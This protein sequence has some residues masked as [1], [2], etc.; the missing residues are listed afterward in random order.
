MTLRSIP[1]FKSTEAYAYPLIRAGALVGADRGTGPI[2]ATDGPLVVVCDS[3]FEAV[4]GAACGGPAE[5][6]VAPQ[7]RFGEPLQRF[8]AAPGRTI[9]IYGPS[10]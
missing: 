10:H 7:D 9:S 1:D 6:V 2:A 4:T 3:L 8:E 5:D